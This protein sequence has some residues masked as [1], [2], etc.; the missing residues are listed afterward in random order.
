MIIAY[1]G[2]NVKDYRQNFLR[3]LDALELT[4][5]D[6][7]GKTRYHGRYKRHI[8]MGEV[9]EWIAINRV[10]CSKCNITHAVMADF[11]RPYKHYSAGDSEMALRDMEDGIPAEKI[12]TAASISTLKRWMAE[13]REKGARTAGMLRS[14]L[15]RLYHRTAS[16]L[17]FAGLK[18]FATW[19]RIL[20][21]LPEIKS[22]NLTI[23]EAN[24][25]ITNHLAGN[26]I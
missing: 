13:F 5:P 18:I 21:E 4:C 20:A 24:Q 9:V 16:E 12:E 6:C 1:L 15:Y 11:I 7:G 10:K 2:R 22:S 17:I 26:F 19:E 25:W 14:L 3:Y 8:H 23:G